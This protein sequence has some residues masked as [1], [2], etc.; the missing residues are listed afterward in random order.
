MTHGSW[1]NTRL[2][3]FFSQ[4]WEVLS[5]H[6]SYRPLFFRNISFNFH[7]IPLSFYYVTTI[8]CVPRI[9]SRESLQLVFWLT[10]LPS[11]VRF[12]CLFCLQNPFSFVPRRQPVV[13]FILPILP[14]SLLFSPSSSPVFSST[15]TRVHLGLPKQ[16]SH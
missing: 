3:H 7:L 11:S 10:S 2:L 9:S 8:I 15:S 14:H 12:P 1:K 5:T 6:L 16:E 13:S 4:G